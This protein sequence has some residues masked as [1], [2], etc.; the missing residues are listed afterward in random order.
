[1]IVH[2]TSRN[3]SVETLSVQWHPTYSIQDGTAHGTGLTSIQT[4]SV[5]GGQS[6]N[7]S[8]QQS[9]KGTPDDATIARCYPS[10]SDVT[11][12]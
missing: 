2:V 10:F 4:T 3:T 9:P 7:V 11:T 5:P 12:G 1:M 6:L 8:A